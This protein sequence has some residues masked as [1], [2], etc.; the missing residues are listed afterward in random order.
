MVNSDL[1]AYVMVVEVN[2]DVGVGSELRSSF[3]FMYFQV[4]H[5]ILKQCGHSIRRFRNIYN[6]K[7]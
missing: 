4:L 5:R 1:V 2:S 7:C 6:R 3:T